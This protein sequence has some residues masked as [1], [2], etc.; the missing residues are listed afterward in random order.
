MKPVEAY[1]LARAGE[2]VFKSAASRLGELVQ[3]EIEE[4]RETNGVDREKAVFGGHEVK[5]TLAK[6]RTAIDGFGEQF[7]DFMEAQGMTTRA[8]LPEWKN[9]V[10]PVEGGKV[11]WKSTGEVVPGASWSRGSDHLSVTGLKDA[12]EIIRAARESGALEAALPMLEGGAE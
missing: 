4:L 1:A 6:G 7:L 10:E 2:R 12:A 5:V 3:D 9:Y 8:V 11:V